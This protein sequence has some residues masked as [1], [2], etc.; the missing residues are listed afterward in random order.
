ML[1]RGQIPGLN[2]IIST[3]VVILVVIS[4]IYAA[5]FQAERQTNAI[6][7]AFDESIFV[8]SFNSASVFS[9][10]NTKINSEKTNFKKYYETPTINSEFKQTQEIFI[11]R[12]F[13]KVI[14][15]IG[16]FFFECFFGKET[17]FKVYFGVKPDPLLDFSSKMILFFNYDKKMNFYFDEYVPA[18]S[19]KI[20]N[21]GGLN[22]DNPYD[23]GL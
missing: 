20:G 4:S 10:L 23:S 13:G 8:D 19:S 12:V 3:V 16:W 6:N 17:S 15:S 18:K 1:K 21:I 14:P 5:M 11:L 2:W 9:Y 22:G 7:T